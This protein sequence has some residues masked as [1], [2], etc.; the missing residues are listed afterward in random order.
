[1]IAC[2]REAS[3]TS[4]GP[5]SLKPDLGKLREVSDRHFLSGMYGTVS[6]RDLL[7]DASFITESKWER[8][9]TDTEAL[10]SLFVIGDAGQKA[11]IRADP[12]HQDPGNPD[13]EAYQRGLAACVARKRSEYEC[14][15]CVQTLSALLQ[16]F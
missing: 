7:W 1:M 15:G 2:W 12:C 4:T 3:G 16:L 9:S 8:L 10:S 6:G 13:L 11:C 14:F 5:S